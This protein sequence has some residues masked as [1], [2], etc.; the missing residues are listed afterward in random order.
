MGGAGVRAAPV[1]LAG[2]RRSGGAARGGGGAGPAVRR[3]PQAPGARLG[4]R[5]ARVGAHALPP[6]YSENSDR[7]IDLICNEMIPAVADENLA[8]YCD[9]FCEKG[10]FSI[11]QS[12]RVL[13][14][15]IKYGLKPRLHADE[16]ID[17]GAAELASEIGAI[18]ADHLMAVSDSGINKMA[19]AGVIATLLP[20]T[21]LFLGQHNYADGRK[22]IDNGLEIA[23]AT[24]FNPGSSTLNCLPTAMALATLYCGLTIEEAFKAVTFNSAKAINMQDKMGMIKNGYQADLLF[25]NINSIEEIPYW[26]GSDRMINIMKK[27]DFLEE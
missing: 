19:D 13:A 9:I 12:R 15:G 17:S 16:F 25:W 7:Y 22:M 5:A 21:T 6:E 24:D 8:I 18:S 1:G 3:A 14:T 26:L 27:G 10:Y 4:P 20:G 2:R 11:D 23:I